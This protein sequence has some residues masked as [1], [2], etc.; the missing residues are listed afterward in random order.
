MST[1]CP[2]QSIVPAGMR[3]QR[4]RCTAE[5]PAV[6]AHSSTKQPPAQGGCSYRRI[7]FPPH[8]NLRMIERGSDRRSISNRIQVALREHENLRGVCALNA[9]SPII[10]A[11]FRPTRVAIKTLLELGMSLKPGTRTVWA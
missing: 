1:D 2:T 7:D 8:A 5:V 9:S 3:P 6:Q 11:E 10:V 4:G